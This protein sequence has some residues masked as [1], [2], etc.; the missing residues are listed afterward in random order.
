[1]N[2]PPKKS[3]SVLFRR[4]TVSLLFCVLGEGDGVLFE[5]VDEDIVEELFHDRVGAAEGRA[6]VSRR[7]EV[8]REL[9]N[10]LDDV[11]GA[12]VL[13]LELLHEGERLLVRVRMLAHQRE[14]ELFFLGEMLFQFCLQAG[15]KMVKA[16]EHFTMMR[17]MD[18]EDLVEKFFR[19]SH[20]SAVCNVMRRFQ[21]VKHFRD[22]K[23]FERFNIAMYV[24]LRSLSFCGLIELGQEFIYMLKGKLEISLGST[25][26]VLEAGDS[27]YFTSRTPH[28]LRG[29][30]GQPAEFLDVII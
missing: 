25:V 6:S 12:R 13:I 7:R 2:R 14:D 23:R 1:M 26:H 8:V 9:L 19:F 29:L 18:D 11:A 27:L 21:V 22:C 3:G 24:P 20:E 16:R 17:I 15:I 10:L 5:D 28:A 30:D 4:A